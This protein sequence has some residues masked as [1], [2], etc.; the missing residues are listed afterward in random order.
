MKLQITSLGLFVGLLAVSGCATGSLNPQADKN[1]DGGVSFPEFDAYMKES[2]FSQY[3]ANGDGVVTMKEWRSQNPTGPVSNFNE[4]DANGDGRVTRAQSDAKMNRDGSMK[5]LFQKI[6]TD[7]DGRLSKEE[8][9]A[10][11]ALMKQQPGG[12]E[13]EKLEQAADQ[14]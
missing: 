8:I 3:D 10:F 1:L 9:A 5:K 6:D 4:A 13:M 14:P 7:G 12:T 2:I 11:E